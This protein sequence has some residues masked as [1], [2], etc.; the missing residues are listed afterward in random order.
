MV[1]VQNQ[2]NTSSAN[3]PALDQKIVQVDNEIKQETQKRM[4]LLSEL[5]QVVGQFKK[6]SKARDIQ[7]IEE[8]RQQILNM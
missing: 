4:A 1:D 2:N 5:K 8:I 6:E 3:D 7:A